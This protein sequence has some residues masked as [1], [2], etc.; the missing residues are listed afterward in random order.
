MMIGRVRESDGGGCGDEDVDV[1]VEGMVGKE[2]DW[3]WFEA[4]CS[5]REP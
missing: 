2:E 3:D 5:K 1:E 4:S